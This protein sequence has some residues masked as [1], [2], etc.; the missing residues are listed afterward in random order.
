[1]L[2]FFTAS[3][4]IL[5]QDAAQGALLGRIRMFN[6]NFNADAV[7]TDNLIRLLHTVRG[8]ALRTTIVELAHRGHT[9]GDWV[10][11]DY[12]DGCFG[13]IS[14]MINGSWVVYA[15]CEP[16]DK[17]GLARGKSIKRVLPE[18]VQERLFQN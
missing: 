7:S 6:F 10:P 17:Y 12:G 14:E 4:R 11:A 3:A 15:A 9:F 1:M 16:D 13:L 2:A 18:D 8:A 5:Y